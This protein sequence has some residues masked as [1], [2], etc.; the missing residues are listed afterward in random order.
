MLARGS[1]LPEVLKKYRFF[2]LLDEYK[3]LPSG[4]R[5]HEYK[6]HTNTINAGRRDLNIQLPTNF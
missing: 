4:F 2:L 6:S 1:M 5:L 3:V